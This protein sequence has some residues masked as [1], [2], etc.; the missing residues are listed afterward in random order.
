MTEDEFREWLRVLTALVALI[1]QADT[2]AANAALRRKFA[3]MSGV[4]I[5][6]WGLS[7]DVQRLVAHGAG[8]R[9]ARRE[10]ETYTPQ[11]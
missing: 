4:E 10:S 6:A 7:D 8:P 1:Q 9:R 2:P 3:A 5:K 11:N